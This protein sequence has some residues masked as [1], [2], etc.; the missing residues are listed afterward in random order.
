MLDFF[1]D[2]GNVGSFEYLV[3]VN[4]HGGRFAKIHA[5]G[6]DNLEFSLVV[7]RLDKVLDVVSQFLAP[8]TFAVGAIADEN[9]LSMSAH[10]AK[11]EVRIEKL[12]VFV[13]QGNCYTSEPA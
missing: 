10:G 13:V 7:F 2:M 11:L 1:A 4:H 3:V 6:L 12:E 8:L 9:K 5:F